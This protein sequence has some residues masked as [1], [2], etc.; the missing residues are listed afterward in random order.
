MLE[1]PQILQPACRV[2][3]FELT[4]GSTGD[5]LELAHPLIPEQR[6]SAPKERIIDRLY[7]IPVC[8]QALGRRRVGT[9]VWNDAS[10]S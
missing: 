3:R 7:R 10:F 6:L 1:Y 8:G 4:L 5:A 2:D 9:A